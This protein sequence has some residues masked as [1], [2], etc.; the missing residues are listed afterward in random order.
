MFNIAHSTS[1]TSHFTLWFLSL[2]LV[3]KKFFP[4]LSRASAL[5]LFYT[6]HRFS[7][8]CIIPSIFSKNTMVNSLSFL[9]FLD[10]STVSRDIPKTT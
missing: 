4:Q 1:H 8:T 3:L 2:Y 10:P 6:R 5:A 7:R 9:P